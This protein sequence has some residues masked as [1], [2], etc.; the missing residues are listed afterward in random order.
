MSRNVS[1]DPNH[2]ACSATKLFKKKL[3]NK[4]KYFAIEIV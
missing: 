4:F 3:F 1:Q 2:S